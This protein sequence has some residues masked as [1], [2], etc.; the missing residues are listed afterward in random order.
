MVH[1]S[2]IG[3]VER[4]VAVLIE[5]HGG[6]FPAWLAPVQVLVLP[7]A[8]TEQDVAAAFAA[9][10][11]AAGLRAHVAAGGSLGARIRDGRLAPYIAVI[12]PA[13]ASQGTVALRL[14]DGRQLDARPTAATVSRIGDLVRAYSTNLW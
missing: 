1:R 7:V 8:D 6:A 12:G 9:Q 4:A 14:R 2:I 10:C 11:V 3:T 13:E 5:Q